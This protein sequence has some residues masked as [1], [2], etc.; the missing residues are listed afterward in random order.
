MIEEPA[1]LAGPVDPAIAAELPGLGLAWSEFPLARDPLGPS[2]PELRQR[3]RALSDRVRG[4]TAMA[5][6]S[7]PIPHAYRVLFR[8]L[9]LEPDVHR[10]PIEELVMERLMVGAFPSERLLHDALLAA[11]VETEVGVWALDAGGLRGPLGLRQS[12]GRVAVADDAGPV[13]DLFAPPAGERA[14][15]H[16]TRRLALYAVIAP[17]VPDIA[18]EEA[19]WIAWEIMSA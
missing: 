11:T 15:G 6:R 3:L 1:V 18:V 14:V 7:R 17:G 19:L 4:A 10:V 2:P 5:L 16:A 9:G 13:A 12:A 8:H